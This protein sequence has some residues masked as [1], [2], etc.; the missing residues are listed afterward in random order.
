MKGH[1]ATRLYAK[2][3]RRNNNPKQQ[4]YIGTDLSSL[5]IF[6]IKEIYTD[7]S[8]IGNASRDR[9]K[10]NIDFFWITQEGKYKAPHTSLILYPKYPEVRLSGFVRGCSDAPSLILNT[11]EEGRTLFFG[12]TD[13]GQVLGY[14]AGSSDLVSQELNSTYSWESS[15]VLLHIPID[16]T[17]SSNS[18]ALL[19]R[20][21]KE[22]YQK[23]WV[24][25][26]KLDNHGIAQPYA[27][28]NAGGY[29]LESLFGI[30]P[31]GYGAPDYLGWELKQYG[32][33]DFETY[34]PKSP[35]TLLTPEPDGGIYVD[36]GI[37]DFI[38]KFGYEDKKGT[39]DR[40]NFGGAYAI[41]K[42]FKGNTS[43]NPSFHPDT[44]VKLVV[45]GYD[46]ETEKWVSSGMIALLSTSDEIAAS[47]T[48]AKMLEH[49]NR[50]HRLA[51]YVPSRKCDS[52]TLEFKYGSRILL[53]LGTD[54]TKFLKALS[55][56]LIKYDPGIKMEQASSSKPLIKRRSQ[57]RIDHRSLSDLYHNHEYQ[58]MK[59]L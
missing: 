14:A 33:R 2:R 8:S 28:R 47:W 12:I 48:F 3:L 20:E 35:V 54:F 42:S 41:D 10:A 23:G 21:L 50:K 51:C 45:D 13:N 57:F 24:K 18:K 58:E 7:A 4:I 38:R 36:S 31:N 9:L 29:T 5:N 32:V 17:Q 15:G 11:L 46:R 19:L 1:G 27:G 49:W 26:Q 40:L 55:T 25:S 44:G 34:S 53:G 22:I 16:H 56:G 52:S 43:C 30:K 6:P 37:Q 59:S 39:T